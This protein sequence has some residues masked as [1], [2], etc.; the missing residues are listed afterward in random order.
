LT[1]IFLFVSAVLILAS[2]GCNRPAPPDPYCELI[3]R[4]DSLRE[5]NQYFIE[6]EVILIGGADDIEAVIEIT[7]LANELVLNVTCD[8]SYTAGVLIPRVQY[9]LPDKEPNMRSPFYNLSTGEYQGPQDLVMRLYTIQNLSVEDVIVV[10]EDELVE[11]HSVYADPN[12]RTGIMGRNVCGSPFHITGSPFHIT[13]SPFHITGSPESGAAAGVLPGAFSNQWAFDFIGVGSTR[14]GLTT[15]KNIVVGVFDTSPFSEVRVRKTATSITTTAL[16]DMNLTVTHPFPLFPVPPH[17][18]LT[19]PFN[20]EPHGLFVSGLIYGVAP[21][22]QI[23]LIQVLDGEGCGDLFT[24]A[25]GISYF[26]STFSESEELMK[27]VV[28]NLSL[29]VARP[30]E[31]GTGAPAWFDVAVESLETVLT[32]SYQWGSVIV[33]AAGNDSSIN[34]GPPPGSGARMPAHLPADYQIVIGVAASNQSNQITCYSNEG[35]VMAPGGDTGWD[36]ASST[37]QIKTEDCPNSSDPENCPWGLVS[38]Y[39]ASS[40]PEFA[41]WVGTSFAAPLVSGIA[42]LGF[43]NGQTHI[44]IINSLLAPGVTC[45]DRLNYQPCPTPGVSP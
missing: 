36:T 32:T 25:R 3:N 26:T 10:F 22:S 31:G 27:N 42:A 5:A 14:L 34:P 21:E 45:I 43:D 30:P 41:Y 1:P 33:A 37:C 23:N 39:N 11:E 44:D 2:A 8:L 17:G 7:G 24:L 4:P 28:I 16:P 29:G 15:G 18:G 40:A 35:D 9:G 19:S 12:Y 38:L 20:L 13:G 6:R